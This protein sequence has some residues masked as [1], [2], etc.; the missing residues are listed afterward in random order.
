MSQTFF[1]TSVIANL[2]WL[3]VSLTNRPLKAFRYLC[4][5]FK[6][7]KQVI[8]RV[9]ADLTKSIPLV[10]SLIALKILPCLYIK[11]VTRLACVFGFLKS[12]NFP[13]SSNIRCK[14]L[15]AQGDQNNVG[16]HCIK[17]LPAAL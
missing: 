6:V 5:L 15:V 11:V 17:T 7:R 9:V 12:F 8:N 1:P 14:L 10:F 2:S 13:I 16:I 4:R 3:H